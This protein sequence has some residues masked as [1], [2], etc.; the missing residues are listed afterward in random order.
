MR[1]KER[2]LADVIPR[3]GIGPWSIVRVASKPEA[4]AVLLIGPGGI[5]LFLI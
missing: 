3:S 2:A 4:S 5:Y 1:E